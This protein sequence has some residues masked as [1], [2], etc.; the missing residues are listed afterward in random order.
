MTTHEGKVA[1]LSGRFT[2]ADILRGNYM[3]SIPIGGATTSVFFRQYHAAIQT[4]IEGWMDLGL[5][6][7]T[8]DLPI[9]MDD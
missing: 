1:V 8:V 5:S 9:A 4:V 2:E 6:E 3:A 7:P